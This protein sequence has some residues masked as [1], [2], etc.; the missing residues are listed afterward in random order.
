MKVKDVKYKVTLMI[1]STA[2]SL[3]VSM[4]QEQ[5]IL[6][7]TNRLRMWMICF[8]KSLNHHQRK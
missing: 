1:L 3:V 5:C 6:S 2:C 7:K 4:W 8:S